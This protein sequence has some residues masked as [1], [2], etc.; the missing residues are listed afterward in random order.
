MSHGAGRQPYAGGLALQTPFGKL[1]APNITPDRETG[2]GNWTED[3]FV[4]AMHDGRGRGGK[5]LYPAMP[6]PAYT[7]MTRD[8]ALS[9]RAYLA[10]V[11]PVSN[12]VEVNQLPFP[13]NIR[14][15]LL[16]WDALNFTPGRY[17]PNPQKSASGNSAGTSSKAPRIVVLVT[18]RRLFSAATSPMLRWPGQRC[19]A[20]LPRTSPP[21]H[22]SASV[23]GRRTTSSNI[24]RPARTPGR[25]HPD[26]W[27]KRCST[28]PQR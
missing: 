18:R 26:R 24:S 9:I 13:F 11:N 10:T 12:A 25:W 28:P 23:A 19:K 7:K 1:V 17:Q 16:F 14:L 5:R 22:A 6:Y 20:G 2:I 15:S 4:A 27:R 3:E 21:I 8:D